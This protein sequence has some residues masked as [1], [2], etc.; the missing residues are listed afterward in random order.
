MVQGK[1]RTDLRTIFQKP[2]CI[3]M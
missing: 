1:E 2:A 3:Y